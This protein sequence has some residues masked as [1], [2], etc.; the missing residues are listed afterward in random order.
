MSHRI[1]YRPS[2]IVLSSQIG[3]VGIAVDGN[4]V[5][6]TLTASTGQITIL[7]ER[8][9]AYG[10]NVTLYD[11]G[12]LIEAEMQGSGQGYATFTLKVGNGSAV[13]DSITL[14]VLYCDRYTLCTNTDVFLAENFLTTLQHRRI[15]PGD[16][17]SLSFFANAGE[18]ITAHINVRWRTADSPSVLRQHYG[19]L[20][21]SNV[22][23]QS[24]GIVQLNIIQPSLASTI[25]SI[26]GEK[27]YDVEIVGFTVHVG[28]RSVTV[29]VDHS[30]DALRDTFLF[31]NCFNVWDSA[32]L[33]AVTIA[34][35]DVDR[36]TAV[37]NGKSSFYNQKVTKT[38]ETEVGPLTSDECA[39]LDQ[40][41]TSHWVMR[42]VANP[43]EDSDPVL[44]APV[45]I[46]DST[47]EVSDTDE[48]PQTV[49]FTWRYADNRAMLATQC[50][51]GIF[52]SPYNLPFS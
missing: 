48:K 40:L 44:F 45:L 32:T 10:G 42:F 25:A 3:E 35:T 41:T 28:Q 27:S 6:V 2:G 50:S 49:K 12:S 33:P 37:V 52:R 26:Y 20:N 19:T 4:A 23:A 18:D 39:W 22:K 31:R 13:H 21:G 1:T 8:Y 9:Y 51:P 43:C 30:R 38:Y 15:A 29:Y 16:T 34:K 46:T 11:I 24:T 47:F 14:R 5:D 36:L 17:L 7:S